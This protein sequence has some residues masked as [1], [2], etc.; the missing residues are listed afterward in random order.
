MDTQH[1]ERPEVG[2][3]IQQTHCQQHRFGIYSSLP[4]NKLS[5]GH[6][7]SLPGN[8]INNIK[9]QK[10]ET[11]LAEKISY[12]FEYKKLDIFLIFHS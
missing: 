2:L 9:S 11:K 12:Y 4:D 10:D 5:N 3:P 1:A 8:E 6:V 7:L